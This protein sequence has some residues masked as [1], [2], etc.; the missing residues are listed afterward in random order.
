[1]LL[2]KK[3]FRVLVKNYLSSEIYTVAYH[4]II[5][6]LF[7]IL[8]L[9]WYCTVYAVRIWYPTLLYFEEKF[10]K[11]RHLQWPPHETSFTIQIY[12]GKYFLFF[13]SSHVMI[14]TKMETLYHTSIV[15]LF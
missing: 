10:N 7:I 15:D 5:E 3:Y 14:F 11:V 1:M 2:E 9:A 12:E 4:W 6:Y 13:A 8:G